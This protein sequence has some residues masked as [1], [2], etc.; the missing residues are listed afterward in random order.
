MLK[1]PS[2]APYGEPAPVSPGGGEGV[3]G[4]EGK[5]KAAAA[6]KSAKDLMKGGF[7]KL[8]RKKSGDGA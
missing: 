4:K 5:E 7:G 2:T 1:K 6:L 3:G 8:G